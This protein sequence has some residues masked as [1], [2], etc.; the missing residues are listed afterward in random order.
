MPTYYYFRAPTFTINPESPTAPKLGSIFSSLKRLTGPLNQ[1]D[2]VSPTA[3]LKNESATNKFHDATGRSFTGSAGAYA[4]T[5]GCLGDGDMVYEFATDKKK[6]YRCELLETEEFEPNLD[7]VAQ[8][9]AASQ[10]VQD[11]IADSFV[12]NK[13][14]YMI[15]GLK[16]ATGFSWTT[17]S[18][19]EHGPKLKV[20][21]SASPFGVPVEAGP[22]IDLKFEE[23]RE[24]SPGKAS[25]K[26]VYAYRAIKISPK[27]DG[28]PKYKDISGGQYGTD[29]DE[30]KQEWEVEAMDEQDRV[31]EFPDS[32]VISIKREDDGS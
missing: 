14:V 9:I 25:S 29:D 20:G 18:S 1:Y 3:D 12:G 27:R 26:V 10:K 5:V 21:V 24:L 23:V 30:E 4:S 15:T 13:K 17:S 2:Y 8:S 6:S 19:N 32:T 7:F 22:Q 31:N 11:F 28:Q 16:I